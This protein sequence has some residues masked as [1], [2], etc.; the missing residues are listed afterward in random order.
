MSTRCECCPARYDEDGEGYA[1]LCEDCADETDLPVLAAFD[2]DDRRAMLR[3]VRKTTRTDTTRRRA[4]VRLAKDTLIATKRQQLA[5]QY[6]DDGEDTE[7]D[8]HA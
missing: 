2:E 7:E 3:T 4:L 1:G 5:V 6:D 8:R